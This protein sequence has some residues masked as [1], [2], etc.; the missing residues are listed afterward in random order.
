MPA[1]VSVAVGTLSGQG[2]TRSNRRFLAAG[3]VNITQRTSGTL[4]SVALPATEIRYLGRVFPC[5]LRVKTANRKRKY[6]N[7]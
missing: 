1:A 7:K 4:H 3:C 2:N 6:I 5:P